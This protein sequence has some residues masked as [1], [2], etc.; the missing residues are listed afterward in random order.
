MIGCHN[1]TTGVFAAAQVGRRYVFFLNGSPPRKAIAGAI[2]AWQTWSI[3]GLSVVVTSFEGK[4]PLD[5][6]IKRASGAR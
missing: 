3:E 2:A 1:F 5:V 4:L 6:F